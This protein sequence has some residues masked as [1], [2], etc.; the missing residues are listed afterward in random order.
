VRWRVERQWRGE[1]RSEWRWGVRCGKVEVGV[2]GVSGG[3]AEEVS[4]GGSAVGVCEVGSGGG[5]GSHESLPRV[6]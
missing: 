5:G 2:G 6:L 4:G 3:E 1:M